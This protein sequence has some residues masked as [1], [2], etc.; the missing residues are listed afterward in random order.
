MVKTTEDIKISLN[1]SLKGR[2][3]R[4]FA[5]KKK[6]KKKMNQNFHFKIRKKSLFFTQKLK[7]DIFAS[8]VMSGLPVVTKN[9]RESLT[10]Y[11]ETYFLLEI[12]YSLSVE[13]FRGIF[14]LLRGWPLFL[15][16]SVCLSLDFFFFFF[17]FWMGEGV[18]GG[19]GGRKRVLFS[20]NKEISGIVQKTSFWDKISVFL[21]IFWSGVVGAIDTFVAEHVMNILS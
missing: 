4:V 15:A 1:V 3:K 14:S 10:C 6:K 5:T 18:G 13:N 8:K 9:H 11:Q 16:I 2:P 20:L 19:G 17:F 7:I 21:M 12:N